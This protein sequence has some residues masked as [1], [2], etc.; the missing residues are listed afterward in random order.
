M[1]ALQMMQAKQAQ[2]QMAKRQNVENGRVAPI[3]PIDTPELPALNDPSAAGSPNTAEPPKGAQSLSSVESKLPDLTPGQEQMIDWASHQALLPITGP[4]ESRMLVQK[5]KTSD[6]LVQSAADTTANLVKSVEAGTQEQFHTQM[7]KSVLYN[8]GALVAQHIGQVAQASKLIGPTE[9]DFTQFVGK[10]L[11]NAIDY[12][13]GK[14][15][16]AKQEQAIVATARQAQ[17][18][19]AAQSAPTSMAPETMPQSGVISN[20]MGVQ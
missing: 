4:Q 5:L 9:K 2:S 17:S 13:T 7:D 6:D 18:P 19:D 15:Q 20:A 16:E 3:P 8:T 1:N 11:T 10:T 12:Y 14:A